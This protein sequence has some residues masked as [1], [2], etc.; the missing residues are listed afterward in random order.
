MMLSQ[1]EQAT[2]KRS[3][4]TARQLVPTPK[5]VDRT[6]A[7][8]ASFDHGFAKWTPPTLMRLRSR[9]STPQ[10]NKTKTTPQ[11]GKPPVPAPEEDGS[12]SSDSGSDSDTPPLAVPKKLPKVILRLGPDPTTS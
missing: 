8:L 1:I 4:R 3:G 6:T 10:K 9:Q 5:W 11:K 2:K 7:I 12:S